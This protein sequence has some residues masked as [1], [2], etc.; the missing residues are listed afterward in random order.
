MREIFHGLEC[1][2]AFCKLA[3]IDCML[4]IIKGMAN[5]GMIGIRVIERLR[6]SRWYRLRQL[7]F[8]LGEKLY[9]FF[10]KK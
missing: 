8:F 3:I 9:R 6:V 10:R 2:I 5:L 1:L 7:G 4:F